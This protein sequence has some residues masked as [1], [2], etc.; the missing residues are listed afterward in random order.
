MDDGICGL[1]LSSVQW[2]A[3]KPDLQG[4]KASREPS[5]H[6]VLSDDLTR[7]P[8]VLVFVGRHLEVKPLASLRTQEGVVM[9]AGSR[10]KCALRP[11]IKKNGE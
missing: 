6:T 7:A 3:A 10:G 4:Q 9:E 8:C 11:Y 1:C 2:N 5:H